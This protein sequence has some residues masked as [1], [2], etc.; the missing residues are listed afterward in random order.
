MNRTVWM[1]TDAL[2]GEV[3]YIPSGSDRIIGPFAYSTQVG[4]QK[5]AKNPHFSAGATAA[6][7][8]EVEA[9]TFVQAIFNGFP[10]SNTDVLVLDDGFLPLSPEGAAWIDMAAG[11]ETWT[12]LFDE[13]GGTGINWLNRV[14]YQ[15]GD[16]IGLDMETMETIGEMV[17]ADDD[18]DDEVEQAR[19]LVQDT[20][21]VAIIPELEIEEGPLPPNHLVPL[22]TTFWLHTSGMNKLGLP[23]LEIR[24][25]GAW[26]VPAAG[27][28][29]NAWA[30]YSTK[31]EI[32]DGQKL[33]G[34]GPVPVLLKAE[35]SEHPYWTE[36][37][38]TC[39]TLS[40][41]QVLY[42]NP[43]TTRIVH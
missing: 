26:W 13:E 41:D 43:A 21:K 35:M 28:E 11:R 15:V 18:M 17:T 8:L 37:G 42:Q 40:V 34:G 27:A 5:A 38:K 30:A 9:S 32:K 22:T 10:P 33:Q 31:H 12:P 16:R 6:G 39:L 20:I 29:L 14:L 3:S 25:V 2:S 1:L 4:A 23:E 36:Q 24:G 19:R 7:V